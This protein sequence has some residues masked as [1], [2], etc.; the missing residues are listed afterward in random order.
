M[1]LK[2]R[3]KH[4]SVNYTKDLVEITLQPNQYNESYIAQYENYLQGNDVFLQGKIREIKEDQLVI[5]Y[6]IDDKM[7]NLI[8]KVNQLDSYDRLQLAQ[9]FHKLQL[10]EH[11]ELVPFIHPSNFYI[12]GN[13]IFIAH[14]GFSDYIA[15]IKYTNEEFLNH[16]R[17][18]ILYILNPKLNFDNL[19]LGKGTLKNNLAQKIE[20]AK[21]IEDIIYIVDN[22]VVFEEQNRLA[23]YKT[24]K[25]N[26]YL[27]FKWLSIILGIISII[28][29]CSVTY[30]STK[31]IPQKN[32]VIA[33]E[34]LYINKDYSG[35]LEKLKQDNPK[36]LPKSAQYIYAVSAVELDDLNNNQKEAVLRN[37]SQKSNENVLLYWIYMGR[38]EFDKAVDIALNIGDNQYILHAYLKLYEVTKA[39]TNMSGNKKQELLSKY[40]EAI[41]KYEKLL[42]GK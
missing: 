12:K 8:S 40:E 1:K 33:A 7:T 16:Y 31:E 17:A 20:S 14:R 3:D 2:D 39:D 9:N 30:F 24:V 27:I 42:G 41:K 36:S 35:I 25:K 5:S 13:R 11:L 22:Q 29:I 23:K 26:K 19:I 28:S 15:P 38:S 6:Q 10:W 34:S 37:L 4:I 21:T 18:L 32:R